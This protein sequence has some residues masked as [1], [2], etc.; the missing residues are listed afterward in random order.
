MAVGFSRFG[1]GNA[2]FLLDEV[3]CKGVEESISDCPHNGW[4][5]HN[6]RSF[7]VA[8]VECKANKG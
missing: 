1:S 6:C 4:G 8:G 7:E 5:I 3:A 2:N